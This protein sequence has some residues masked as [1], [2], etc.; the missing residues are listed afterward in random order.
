[1]SADGDVREH[2]E[3]SEGVD[4]PELRPPTAGRR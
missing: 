4:V 1:M 2:S 3:H